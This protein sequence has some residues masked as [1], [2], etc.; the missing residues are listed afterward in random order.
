MFF[1]DN[2]GAQWAIDEG[3]RDRAGR[4]IDHFAEWIGHVELDQVIF[5]RLSGSKGK[6]HGKC[7]AIH[8]AP[9]TLIPKYVVMKL[10]EF[11]LLKL[12]GLSDIDLDIFDIRYVIVI[13]DDSIAQAEGELQR[14]ED[15]TLI[16]EMMHIHEDGVKLV[17]HDC[18]D[19]KVL[20]DKFGPYWDE[21]IFKD[22]TE[23]EAVANGEFIEGMNDALD[24]FVGP[25][26]TFEAVAPPKNA[27]ALPPPPP[28]IPKSGTGGK[29][30][31]DEST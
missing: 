18:E 9:V 4:L 26:S 27:P 5:I 15:S 25:G 1:V 13:N 22:P 28:F 30:E 31:F 3:L 19:F 12:D 2:S 23:E 16:H 11:N 21:G 7:F 29:F 6:F 10:K 20:V 14:V 17:K 24:A 8:K